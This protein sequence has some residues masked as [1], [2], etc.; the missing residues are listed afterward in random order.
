MQA[1]AGIAVM[2]MTLYGFLEGGLVGALTGCVVALGT[3]S[4]VAITITPN[5][6]GRFPGDMPS[7]AQTN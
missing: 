2:G 4:A 1:L 6:T 5:G 3:S 7:Y